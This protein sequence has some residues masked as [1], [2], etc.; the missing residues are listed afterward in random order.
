[1]DRSAWFGENGLQAALSGVFPGHR[2]VGSE[3]IDDVLRDVRG[4]RQIPA[5]VRRNVHISSGVASGH[6]LMAIR[7][8]VHER[9]FAC[10]RRSW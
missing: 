6:Q 7:D 5:D 3:T 2:L 1:M 4:L 8:R 10:G 9:R